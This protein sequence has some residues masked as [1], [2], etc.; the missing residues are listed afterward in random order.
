[1]IC[2][3]LENIDYDNIIINDP[4]K[5]SVMQYNYFYKLFNLFFFHHFH[6]SFHF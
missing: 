3:N 5:N 6:Y 2:E 4:I 1:M